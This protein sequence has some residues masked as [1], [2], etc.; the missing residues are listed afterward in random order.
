LPRTFKTRNGEV[1]T[2]R[3]MKPSDAPLL[4]QLFYQLS[5]ESRWRRFHMITDHLP[6]Q[7]VSHRAR[8]LAA[9]D[10]RTTSGAVVAVAGEGE[11]AAIVGVVRLA[12]PFDHPDA[13]EAEAAI[14][15]RDDYQG[16]GIGTELLRCMVVLARR[17]R[18]KKILAVFQPDN[19][20]AIR[21]FRQLGLPYKL[22][23]THGASKMYL[24]APE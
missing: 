8:E 24:E 3:L 13:P 21:L 14:V 16:Q 10:N 20:V 2:L 4:E 5:P 23:A 17:M 12:R 9:V 22:T 18:V 19:D 15:V 1:L 11:N 6:P 7:E